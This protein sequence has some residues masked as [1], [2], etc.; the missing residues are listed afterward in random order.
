[1]TARSLK[2]PPRLA[3]FIERLWAY[4]ST[5]A[6]AM[7]TV[8]PH[9][10]MQLLVNL[11]PPVAAMPRAVLTGPATRARAVD[12]RAMRR[13]VGVLFRPGG[14]L[15]F[16]GGPATAVANTAI[17]LDLI[18]GT[19]GGSLR[20]RLG[21]A[22]DDALTALSDALVE[23]VDA[24]AFEPPDPV[25]PFAVDALARGARVSEVVARTGWARATVVRR[26]STAVGLPPKQFG[27]VTRFQHAV[28]RLATGADPRCR[29]GHVRIL[30]PGPPHARLPPVRGTFSRSVPTPLSVGTQSRRRYALSVSYNT[31]GRQRD[32]LAA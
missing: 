7:E 29:R 3:P 23:R 9:G 30:R 8:L 5:H 2:P 1:M 19:A 25:V 10:K 17:D 31:G 28:R 4:E 20:D 21:E 18:W 26:F 13:I 11:G 16:I 32:T 15:P 14:A 27:A 22:G 6:H 12:T 24:G